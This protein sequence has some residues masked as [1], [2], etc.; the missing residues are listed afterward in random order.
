MNSRE[1]EQAIQDAFDGA[2]DDER[3]VLL[4]QALKESPERL[5]LYCEY[6]LLES[7]IRR[8]TDGHRSLPRGFRTKVVAAYHRLRANQLAVSILSTAAVL[9]LAAILLSLIRVRNSAY[10]VKMESSP[11]SSLL[12]KDGSVFHDRNLKRN[13][14]VT[15]GQGV[16]RLK[17][18]SG[19]EAVIEGPATFNLL[20]KDRLELASGH[21][22][23]HVPAEARGF[24]VTSSLLEVVDLG[25]EFGIDQREDLKPQVH[26]LKGRVEIS[27]RTGARQHLELQAGQAAMLAPEGDWETLS[28]V[29]DKFREHLP[30]DLPELKMDFERIDD[31]MLVIEGD[32]LGADHAQAR[33]LHPELVRLVPGVSGQ[34]LELRG[35]GASIETNWQG[36][37]GTAPRTVSLWCRIPQ[38]AR[39]QTAPP[40]VWWGNPEFG[41]NRKFKV[42]LFTGANGATVLRASFGEY[43]ADGSANL[44]DGEWHHLAVVYRSNHG[45]GTPDLTCYVDGVIEPLVR[46]DGGSVIVET[47]TRSEGSGSMGIGKYELPGKGRNPYLNATLDDLRIIAGAMDEESIRKLAHAR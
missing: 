39:Q 37:A 38:G 21:A 29:S 36:I 46:R 43:F 17:L 31:G 26:V 30:Q 19:V 13:E 1:L 15:L 7:E 32:M 22:W 33:I 25:T 24:R 3:A 41:K 47:D 14:P 10:L 45:S 20:E 35:N 8:H 11:G 2:L 40:L 4:R 34:A 6:A 5:E 9:L 18:D 27:A 12:R 23:F 42:A 28:A 44:A 16:V